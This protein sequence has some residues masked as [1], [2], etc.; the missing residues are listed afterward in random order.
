MVKIGRDPI[1][2]WE[3]DRIRK[4]LKAILSV[5]MDFI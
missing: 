1:G 5:Q 3:N 2:I 4:L